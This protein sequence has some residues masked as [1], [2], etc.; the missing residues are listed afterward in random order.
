MSASAIRRREDLGGEVIANKQRVNVDGGGITPVKRD[1]RKASFSP[2]IFVRRYLP[3][4][5]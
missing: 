5:R 3:F 2:S 4:F 1:D